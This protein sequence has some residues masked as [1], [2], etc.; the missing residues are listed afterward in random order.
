MSVTI[1]NIVDRPAMAHE[2][3][4][5]SNTPIGFTANNIL[6][7]AGN[8]IGKNCKRVFCTVET[9]EIRFTTDGTAPSATVGHLLRVNDTLELNNE[10]DIRN[11]R[12]H[13]VTTDANLIVTYKF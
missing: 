4:T 6:P 3:I 13:R 10:S 7:I 1:V 11:F 9:D 5:V 2:N 12:A 8:Y